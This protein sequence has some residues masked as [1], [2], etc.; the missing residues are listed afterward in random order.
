MT[1]YSREALAQGMPSLLFSASMQAQHARCLRAET[2]ALPGCPQT[3]AKIEVQGQQF[4]DYQVSP[5]KL[6]KLPI[7]CAMQAILVFSRG[8][9]S[10]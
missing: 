3:L 9:V 7:P 4:T 10:K 1:R 6:V 8:I 2:V 5:V